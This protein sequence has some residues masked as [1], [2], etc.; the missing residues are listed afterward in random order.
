MFWLSE[1]AFMLEKIGSY[2]FYINLIL[3][4][5]KLRE[6]VTLPGSQRKIGTEPGLGPT[7]YRKVLVS[8]GFKSHSYI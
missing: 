3:H 8:V 5:N 1:K 4:M 7:Q 6:E 2:T